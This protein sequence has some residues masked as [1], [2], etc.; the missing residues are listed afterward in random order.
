MTKLISRFIAACLTVFAAFMLISG[1]IAMAT[2]AV[3]AHDPAIMLGGFALTLVMVLL[4][5]DLLASMVLYLILV[6]Q[7][8]IYG[9]REH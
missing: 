7:G 9:G 3:G 5:A 2:Y 6:I 4:A 8:I 1:A